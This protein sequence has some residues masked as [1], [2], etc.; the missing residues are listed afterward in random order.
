MVSVASIIILILGG[1]VVIALPIVAGLLL[2]RKTKKLAVVF[3]AGFLSFFVMQILIR[4]PI[5]QQLQAQNW[6]QNLGYVAT[7]LLAAVSAALFETV[8][9]VVTVKM[10]LK[11]NY[12][13]EAGI[14]HGIAHGGTEAILLV[15]INFIIYG[16]LGIFINNGL[17]D[18]I[19]ANNPSLVDSFG[20]LKDTL[21]TTTSTDYFW[22]IFERIATMVIQVGMSLL[23]VY[24]FRFDKKIFILFV[25]LFHSFI[26]FVAVFALHQ[27]NSIIL[28]EGLVFLFALIMVF[29]IIKVKKKY[30][31]IT[32]DKP[33][34]IN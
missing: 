9:R 30:E 5:L 28:T 27:T 20:Q 12:R 22:G 23:I 29:T 4:I 32:S 10:F 13:F 26:D 33:E 34:I 17:F 2:N 16:I 1:I 14:A 31:T 6:Y 8:G 11:A 21:T 18:S 19:L 7:I 3:F 25:F 24:A 15:G